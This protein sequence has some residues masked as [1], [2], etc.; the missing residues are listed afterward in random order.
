MATRKRI[1]PEAELESAWQC[2]VGATLVSSDGA[3]LRLVYPGRLNRAWGPDIRDGVVWVGGAYVRGDIELHVEEAEWYRHG[4]CYDPEYNNVMLHVVQRRTNGS[5]TVTQD[6]RN[7][8]VMPLSSGLQ[9][10]APWLP[11]HKGTSD[12]D[13]EALMKLLD[14]AGWERFERKARSL[15]QDIE[16]NGATQAFWKVLCRT[17]GYS[18]NT[19]AFEALSDRLPL[20]TLT[21]LVAPE[22]LTVN[23]AWMLGVAGLLPSQRVG[24]AADERGAR[25]ERIWLSLPDGIERIKEGAWDLA[26]VY[27]NNSPV[28]RIVGLSYLIMRYGGSNMARRIMCLVGEPEELCTGF[29]VLGDQY[30]RE[31]YDFGLRTRKSAVLGQ[32]KAREIAVNSVLPFTFAWSG[33]GGGKGVGQR[34]ADMYTCFPGGPDNAITLHMKSQLGLG[35]GKPLTACRQQ[36]LIHLYRAYCCVGGCVGCPVASLYARPARPGGLR[37][38][39]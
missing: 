38:K 14:R 2:L 33:V 26:Q 7:V 37:E 4:H 29:M 27:P 35:H 3:R 8:L 31:H 13:G 36:G 24:T 23:Q 18:R 30:W 20:E 25:L 22:D 1:R 39:C 15:R 21:R 32:G 11:C 10:R 16:R 17:M 12:R 28:R 19:G 34:A 5:G 6:G 9:A